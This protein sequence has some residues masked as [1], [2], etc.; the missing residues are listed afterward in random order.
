MRQDDRQIRMLGPLFE[1][2]TQDPRFNQVCRWIHGCYSLA[3]FLNSIGYRSLRHGLAQISQGMVQTLL[4][5]FLH[6]SDRIEASLTPCFQQLMAATLETI[7]GFSYPIPLPP[8]DSSS[9]ISPP[10][11]GNGTYG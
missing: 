1:Q 9:T 5:Q 11:L 4:P 8:L 2:P 7:S 10:S 6:N 3:Q